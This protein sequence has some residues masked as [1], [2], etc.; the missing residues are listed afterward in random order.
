MLEEVASKQEY[1]DTEEMIKW[2][3]I[4]QEGVDALW[5]EL[6]GKLGGGTL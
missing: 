3:N 2:R 6:C 4:N 5:K 1:E